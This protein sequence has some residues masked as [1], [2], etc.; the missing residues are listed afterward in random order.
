MENI[1]KYSLYRQLVI[2]PMWS[3]INMKSSR[4]SDHHIDIQNL[5]R[6][7][8][9][10]PLRPSPSGYCQRKLPSLKDFY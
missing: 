10:D 6:Y 5:A 3:V 4:E 7:I 8:Q 9:V 2:I 1:A